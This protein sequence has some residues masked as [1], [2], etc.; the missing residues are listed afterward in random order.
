M[1]LVLIFCKLSLAAMFVFS[2]VTKLRDIE[3]L[4]EHIG[5]TVSLPLRSS[6]VAWSVVV[7]EAAA[8][9]GLVLS[10]R[11]G[12]LVAAAVL[13]GFTGYLAHVMRSGRAVSCG[14]TGSSGADVSGIHLVR[15]GIALALAAGGLFAPHVPLWSHA[16]EYAVMTGPAVLSGVALL[17]LAELREFLTLR[18]V[19]LGARG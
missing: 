1:D 8:V 6:A 5:S 18:P 19:D 11:V 16:L 12:F 15:N 17:Y 2:S 14:C 9:L 7:A 4:A 10:D 3:A 13:I